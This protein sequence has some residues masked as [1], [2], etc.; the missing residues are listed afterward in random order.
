MALLR[1]LRSLINR[2]QKS[3][4]LQEELRFHLETETEERRERGATAEAA[5]RA[6]R[7]DFGNI[8]VVAEDTRATWGWTA[9]EQLGQDIRYAIRTLS[10]SRTFTIAAVVSLALGIG[11]NT[12][13]YT[14]TDA[15]LLR[16]LPVSDPQ[17]LVR[18]TWRT[19]E[20]ENHGTGSHDSAVRSPTAG[21]TN[22]V[23][24]YAAFE[25]FDRHDQ[26]FSSVFAYQ[27]TRSI[28]LTVQDQTVPAAGEYVSGNYFRGLG[29]VPS[30]GRW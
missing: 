16:A 1:R 15:I 24:A 7:L 25:L 19:P 13:L 14:L 4:D 10:K 28:S 11:A 27:R 6:A 3:A 5:E 12:L 26:I 23:F 20:P 17:T 21:Y 9:F 29:I 30:A 22:G 8:A 2:K 18:M